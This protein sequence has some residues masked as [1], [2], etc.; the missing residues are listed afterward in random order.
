VVNA[1]QAGEGGGGK[2][3]FSKARTPRVCFPI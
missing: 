1:G 2:S 3:G